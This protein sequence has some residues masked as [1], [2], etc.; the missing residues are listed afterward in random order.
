LVNQGQC[1]D[2]VLQIFPILFL[3]AIIPLPALALLVLLLV[4]AAVNV[5]VCGDLVEGLLDLLVVGHLGLDDV[6][7]GLDVFV[8]IR[9]GLLCWSVLVVAAIVVIALFLVVSIGNRRREV[10][11]LERAPR[12]S[13]IKGSTVRLPCISPGVAR[14]SAGYHYDGE[15]ERG[16]SI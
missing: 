3:L 2:P 15:S 9:L 13:R 8:E 10:T 14:V 11:I 4:V 7:E 1:R 16:K 12:G 6:D 5:G